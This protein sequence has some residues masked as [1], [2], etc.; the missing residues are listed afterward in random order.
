MNDRKSPISTADAIACF[1]AMAPDVKASFLAKLAF[2]LT[3]VARD[4][5]EVGGSGLTDPEK[6]RDMNEVQHRILGFLSA[7]LR[8]DTKRYP[9]DVLVQIVLEH[10][11]DPGL[12]RQMSNAFSRVLALTGVAA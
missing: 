1:A 6:M 8:S 10:P 7:L 3:I 5:Y 11:D 4:T 12:H 9:D 2:E